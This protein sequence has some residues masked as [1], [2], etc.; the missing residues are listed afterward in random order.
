MPHILPPNFCRSHRRQ[1]SRRIYRWIYHTVL[2]MLFSVGAFVFP[3]WAHSLTPDAVCLAELDRTSSG[4]RSFEILNHCLDRFTELSVE[5]GEI[6]RR[7][8]LMEYDR[9]GATGKDT[10]IKGS[11]SQK[12]QQV[13]KR[14]AESLDIAKTTGD[15]SL[16]NRSNYTLGQIRVNEIDR[17]LR[18]L[19][20]DSSQEVQA[21]QAQIQRTLLP[22]S[23][24]N[25]IQAKLYQARVLTTSLP[26]LY[27]A[28]ELQSQQ[29]LKAKKQYDSDAQTAL[30]SGSP[31]TRV[32]DPEPQAK[33]D[34]L[35][36]QTRTWTTDLLTLLP[37]LQ[38][39]IA[40][41]PETIAL[42]MYHATTLTKLQ[43]VRSALNQLE[44]SR[45]TAWQT[46]WQAAVK[47]QANQPYEPFLPMA[48]QTQLAQESDRSDRQAAEL[49]LSTIRS[50]RTTPSKSPEET[51]TLRKQSLQAT[52]ALARLY[53][54]QN[55]PDIAARLLTPELL[56]EADAIDS[57]EIAGLLYGR[58]AHLQSDR[59]QCKQ[60][61]NANVNS[62]DCAAAR[63]ASD[64]AIRRIELVRGDLLSL[65]P[66]LQYSYREGVE[67]LYRDNLELQLMQSNP[68]LEAVLARMESLKLA[69][70]HNYFRE[71]CVEPKV[72]LTRFINQNLPN[73]NLIYTIALQDRLEIIVK[74]AGQSSNLHRYQSTV[75]RTTL[76]ATAKI[77]QDQVVRDRPNSDQSQ[78]LYNWIFRSID[79]VTGRTLES[80]LQPESTLVMVSDSGL[81]EIPMAALYDGKQSLIDRF[82]VALSPGLTLF[83]PKPIRKPNVMFAGQTVF[84]QIGLADL[85][86]TKVELLDLQQNQFLPTQIPSQQVLMSEEQSPYLPFT[87]ANFETA[88]AQQ[89]FNVVHLAT[90]ANFGSAQD[91]TFIVMGN[92]KVGTEA[93]SEALR[94]RDRNREDSIEL[95]ILSAC[96]TAEGDDRAVLGLSGLAIRSGA[97]ST[98]AT[99][100]NASDAT[101]VTPTVMRE[102]YQG[103]FTQQLSKA[104][105]LRKALRRLK[106]QKPSSY[107]APYVVVGN[108][109]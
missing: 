13:E 80:D 29:V 100:W 28:I 72:Q 45:Q 7:L 66:D 77:F 102:F 39:P 62:R 89:G 33:L 101:E 94:N 75:S 6:Q 34:R 85:K 106:T 30:N 93:F 109:L 108:W 61:G 36:Q 64:T 41:D 23:Q 70:V 55:Q 40:T 5:R 63:Q 86:G 67:P 59:L 17:T 8:A 9:I 18:L 12:I 11:R 81:R 48:V 22:L 68:D 26:I 60:L 52:L 79:A 57:P 24:S 50:A 2:M 97:R 105:A 20:V 84:S 44:I 54:Q 91:Q 49:F 25:Q 10:T 90:H 43:P 88:I 87:L 58:Y 69:E 99:L 96:K 92:E 35:S 103:V 15:V 51:K 31:L 27:R 98:I 82:A 53:E 37:Q 78:S 107:W 56:L 46:A 73:T 83:D 16:L 104:Q 4:N 32:L 47:T 76:E 71:P 65:S 21:F 1:I 3:H 95:L 38:S 14:I 42:S 74:L 19:K